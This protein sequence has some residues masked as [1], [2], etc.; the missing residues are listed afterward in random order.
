[1]RCI[2]DFHVHSRYSR[3]TSKEMDLEGMARW[4]LKKGINLL[5][6]GDFTHPLYLTHIKEKVEQDEDG[7]FYLKKGPKEPRFLLTTEVS[8]IFHQ[9]GKLRKIHTLLFAPSLEVVEKI[10][11]KLESRGNLR[12]DGRPIFTF[13]AKDLVKMVLDCS[14]ECMVVPAHA[15]TP[16]FSIFGANSGFDSIEECFEEETK[17]IFAIETGLSSDPGMNWRLTALDTICLI[18]NSDAHSPSKIGREANVFEG[19]LNYH[20]LIE[21]IRKHDRKRFLYTIEFYPE[22]GKYHYDGHRTCGVLFSPQMTREHHGLCPV[23]HKKVTIGVMNRVERLADRSDG[24]V[25]QGAIPCK[26]L[27]PL[28]EILA[29]VLGQA[30]STKG[31]AREYERLLEAMG[32]EFDI[33]LEHPLEEIAKH[34]SEKTTEAIRKVREGEVNIVPGYDGV[35]GKISLFGSPEQ[36]LTFDEKAIPQEG[37]QME[38]F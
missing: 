5:S 32:L 35:Y 16:W 23:C 37:G 15:W 25:P 2:A 6:T 31:V 12:A 9:K 13:L 36:Q 26:H 8:N 33:L 22:E 14:D 34:A 19:P 17:N 38:L 4:A 1:M 3:A 7:F 20:Q 29:E 11:K 10:N 30:V 21:A 24:F 28:D 18:S 27:I